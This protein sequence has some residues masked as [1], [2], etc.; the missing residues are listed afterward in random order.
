VLIDEN[1]HARLTD[2]GLT[3]VLHATKTATEARGGGSLRWMAPEL[4]DPE[5]YG[6]SE[7]EAGIPTKQSDVYA[8]A[9][10]I[11]EVLSHM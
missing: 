9:M 10:T 5:G 8:L 3:I 6:I 11:W 4:L 2:F 1:G 7:V